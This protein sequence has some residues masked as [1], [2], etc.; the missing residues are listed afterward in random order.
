MRLTQEQRDQVNLDEVRSYLSAYS[1]TNMYIDSLFDEIDRIE[2]KKVRLTSVLSDMPKGNGKSVTEKWTDAIQRLE[3]IQE[4]MN[5]EAQELSKE[6]SDVRRAIK[7]LENENQKTVLMLRYVSG[8]T[9]NEVV[10]KLRGF[11]SERQVFRIHKE[12]LIQV[13]F[14]LFD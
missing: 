5:I 14:L 13:H 3:E 4:E 2:S 12:A 9:W 1:I 11:Y 7:S 10:R 6:L 8:L